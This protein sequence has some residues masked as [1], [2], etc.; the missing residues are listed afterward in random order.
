MAETPFDAASAR[1]HLALII[2]LIRREVEISANAHSATR[3]LTQALRDVFPEREAELAA[4]FAKHYA[5][6]SK[7]GET[8]VIARQITEEVDRIFPHAKY[9]SS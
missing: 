4:A 1:E 6:E 9:G 2:H 3:A 7:N 5:H 8:A